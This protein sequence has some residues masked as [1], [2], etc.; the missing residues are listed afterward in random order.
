LPR[1]ASARRYAQAAFDIAR[2]R[3]EL[4]AW[5]SQLRDIARALEVPPWAEVL[6]SLKIP[7]EVKQTMLSQAFPEANPLVLNLVY[8]LIARRRLGLLPQIIEQY[9]QLLDAHRGIERAR[10]ITA[11][12][13][14]EEE[15]QRL[16]EILG[17]IAAKKVVVATEIDP[18]I[19]GG[20]VARLGDKL[21]DGSVRSR[22]ENLRRRLARAT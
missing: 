9:E 12:P 15:K 13:L 6:E 20:V 22:L 4:E 3:D 10:V 14:E 17:N 8:L 11:V 5:R 18:D 19:I 2:E 1:A 16:A 21:I 7:F